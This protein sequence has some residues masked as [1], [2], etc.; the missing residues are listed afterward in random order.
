MRTGAAEL[1]DGEVL[2]GDTTRF[3]PNLRVEAVYKVVVLF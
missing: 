3:V 2:A 1:R